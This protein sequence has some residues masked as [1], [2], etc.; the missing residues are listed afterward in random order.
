[1][2]KLKP[3]KSNVIDAHKNHIH[4]EGM[5]DILLLVDI[6]SSITKFIALTTTYE[7]AKVN[8][9]VSMKIF[10][11]DILLPKLFE[12]KTGFKSG[13]KE[14]TI[15]ANTVLEEFNTVKYLSL[16]YDTL[17]KIIDTDYY[18]EGEAKG[19]NVDVSILFGKDDVLESDTDLYPQ[20]DITRRLGTLVEC[21]IYRTRLDVI[22]GLSIEDKNKILDYTESFNEYINFLCV[23]K[24]NKNNSFK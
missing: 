24:N 6:A 1:M 20:F 13:T 16:V 12:F 23:G 15:Y 8:G 4:D 9:L 2:R 3:K 14:A 5:F 19:E 7:Y 22:R 11:H 17:N 10:L 21:L 18:K